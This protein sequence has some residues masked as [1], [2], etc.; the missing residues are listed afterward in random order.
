M[1][2]MI[3]PQP[4]YCIDMGQADTDPIGDI[5]RVRIR[6]LRELGSSQLGCGRDGSRPRSIAWAEASSRYPH[7][8]IISK[9][10]RILEPATDAAHPYASTLV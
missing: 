3:Q 1:P 6:G 2:M 4:G 9:N 7:Q 10:L 8:P 5:S